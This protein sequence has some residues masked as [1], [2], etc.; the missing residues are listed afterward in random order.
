M[1]YLIAMQSTV[2]LALRLQQAHHGDRIRTDSPFVNA[3]Q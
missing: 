1:Q 2:E 3:A